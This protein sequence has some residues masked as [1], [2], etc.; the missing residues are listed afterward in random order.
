MLKPEIF[1]TLNKNQSLIFKTICVNLLRVF[2]LFHFQMTLKNLY[3]T[4][5]GWTKPLDDFGVLKNICVNFF[6]IFWV[7]FL[8]LTFTS[9]WTCDL[10]NRH[11]IS[12]TFLMTLNQTWSRL[13]GFRFGISDL[14]VTLRI[15]NSFSK[16]RRQ[17]II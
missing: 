2:S 16:I 14:K 10:E 9:L 8:H 3:K 1:K 13:S 4:F 5:K 15:L 17:F 7:I 6:W 11:E 12:E